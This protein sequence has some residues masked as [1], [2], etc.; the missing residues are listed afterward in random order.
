M[1]DN[2]LEFFIQGETL[3][4]I[5]PIQEQKVKSAVWLQMEFFSWAMRIDEP[6]EVMD[7]ILESMEEYY[8][9]FPTINEYFERR[10]HNKI[11]G[12]IEKAI[13]DFNQRLKFAIQEHIGFLEG[14]LE[15]DD[16]E[17]VIMMI[18]LLVYKSFLEYVPRREQC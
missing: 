4:E 3:E 5:I 2:S 11:E 10:K 18:E 17:T 16:F 14:F 15:V 6:S 12:E 1:K 7:L 13:E 9:D 8:V